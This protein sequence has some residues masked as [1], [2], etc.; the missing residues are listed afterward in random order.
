MRPSLLVPLGLSITLGVAACGDYLSAP[1]VT[2][3]PTKVT[4]LTRPG[5]L[6]VGVQ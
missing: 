2:S 1:D 5:P 3:D 4:Q 6:Y